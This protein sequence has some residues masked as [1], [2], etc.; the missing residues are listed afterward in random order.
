MDGKSL[1]VFIFATGLFI[2]GCIFSGIFMLNRT[3]TT[4]IV[5]GGILFCTFLFTFLILSLLF[6]KER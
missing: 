5:G 4:Y 1:A 6:K 3:L 2:V